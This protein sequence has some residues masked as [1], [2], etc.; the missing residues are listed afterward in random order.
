[1]QNDENVGINIKKIYNIDE[2]DPKMT[3]KAD[4]QVKILKI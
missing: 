2:Q 3:Y 4:E 1:M